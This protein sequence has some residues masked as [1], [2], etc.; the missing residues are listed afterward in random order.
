[1]TTPITTRAA[2]VAALAD[3]SRRIEL[4]APV[5][6]AIRVWERV[7]ALPVPAVPRPG[8][9][10]QEAITAQAAAVVATALKSRGNTVDPGTVQAVAE[11]REREQDR[12]DERALVIAVRAAAEQQ[13]AHVSVA[14]QA[15][16]IAALR[17]RHRQVIA[18]LIDAAGRLP[19]GALTD[20]QVLRL[21]APV[22]DA[23]LRSAD[24][25]AEAEV[26]LGDVRSVDG[27][28]PSAALEPLARCLMHVRTPVVYEHWQVDGSTAFG[29]VGSLLFYR[30]LAVAVPDPDQWWC[31][32]LTEAVAL[33][34]EMADRERVEALLPR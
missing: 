19:E 29:P 24:L 6:S 27:Q 17:A 11:A 26:L 32:T 15:A 21:D 8:S 3:P 23:Y 12:A 25:A 22:R 30:A 7:L 14:H 4:P 31:P 10:V 13:L 5:L 16:I 2:L 28:A 33:A 9:L 34:D 18:E 1:M 20:G